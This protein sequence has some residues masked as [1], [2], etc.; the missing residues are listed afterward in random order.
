MPEPLRNNLIQNR[1]GSRPHV[2]RPL[3]HV[4]TSPNIGREGAPHT[5]VPRPVRGEAAGGQ[6]TGTAGVI[7]L[8]FSAAWRSLMN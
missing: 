4:L 5:T 7:T 1:T 8:R 2:N 6:S 3:H